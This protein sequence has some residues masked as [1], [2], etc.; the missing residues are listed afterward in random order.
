MIRHRVR[1]VSCKFHILSLLF[2]Q[3]LYMCV[4]LGQLSGIEETEIRATTATRPR[5]CE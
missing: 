3:L 1:D 5:A 4:L 2:V